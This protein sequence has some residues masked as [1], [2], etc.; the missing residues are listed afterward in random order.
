MFNVLICYIIVYFKFENVWK[1]GVG[2]GVVGVLASLAHRP[3]TGDPKRGDPTNRSHTSHFSITELSHTGTFLPDSPFRIPLF[4]SP[5]GGRR[6]V[7][8]IV[9][10]HSLSG[11]AGRVLHM[12]NTCFIHDK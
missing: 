1:V 7:V 6:V 8:S 5:I 9:L 2:V 12:Y 3:P 4:G 11:H 10:A